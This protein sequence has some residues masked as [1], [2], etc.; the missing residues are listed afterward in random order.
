MKYIPKDPKTPILQVVGGTEAERKKDLI[1]EGYMK[2][3]S[4]HLVPLEMVKQQDLLRDELVRDIVGTALRLNGMLREFKRQ[5]M[6][7]I[8]DLVDIAADE[9]DVQMG[10]RKGNLSLLSFD[11]TLKVTR[12][13]S[14]IVTFTEELEAA[15][16]LINACVTRWS[17]GANP[18]I[19]A[20][21]DRAFRTD[22]KGQIKTSAVLELLRLE[23]QD[24]EWTRAMQAL[25]DSIQSAGTSTYI[26][27]YHRVG[28]SAEWQVIPLDFAAV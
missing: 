15:K 1:P 14:D 17:E 26:R 22:T 20:I 2:N 23:I 5:S 13:M 9:Y 19:R 16:E 3:A 4:G 21:I 11:G 24:E 18:N 8:Q 10:G 27:A 25:R 12:Q 28:D 6:T 7:D